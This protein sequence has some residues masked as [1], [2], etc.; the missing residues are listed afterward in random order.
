MYYRPC[1]YCRSNLDPGERCSCQDKEKAAPGV[2]TTE[3]GT[4]KISTNKINDFGGKVN[5]RN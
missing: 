5:D 3:D 4:G 1:P 2:A